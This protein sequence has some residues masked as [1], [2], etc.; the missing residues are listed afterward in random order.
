MSVPQKQYSL[1]WSKSKTISIS[2]C[3]DCGKYP[4]P[5]VLDSMVVVVCGCGKHFFGDRQGLGGY[6]GAILEWNKNNQ[7]QNEKG[8]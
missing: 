5:I 6:P 4:A 7:P 3:R 1:R 8:K 2:S